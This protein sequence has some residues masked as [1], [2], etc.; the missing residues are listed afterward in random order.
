MT[1]EGVQAAV[2]VA[3]GDRVDERAVRSIPE[4]VAGNPGAIVLDLSEVAFLDSAGLTIL[5]REHNRCADHGVPFRLVAATT[6]VRRP[7]ELTGLDRVLEIHPTVES[8]TA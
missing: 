1:S 2:V 5:V 7:I 3:A 6:V 4:H 8:A